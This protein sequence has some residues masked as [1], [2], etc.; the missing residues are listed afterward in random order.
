MKSSTFFR[1]IATIGGAL[2]GYNIRGTINGYT[3]NIVLFSTGLVVT[4]LALFAM[5][6]FMHKEK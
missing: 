5:S 2:L 6:Y 3:N 1:I 4:T